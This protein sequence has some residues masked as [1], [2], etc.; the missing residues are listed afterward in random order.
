MRWRPRDF[1]LGEMRA[2]LLIIGVLRALIEIAGCALVAR[3][4]VYVML[5]GR[6]DRNPIYRFLELVTRPIVRFMR[7]ITP[8]YLSDWQL[9]WLAFLLLFWIWFALGLVKLRLCALH[10]VAC[11]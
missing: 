5:R 7:A 8:R 10:Q 2:D 1:H 6:A 3:G 4:L 11:V 9:P